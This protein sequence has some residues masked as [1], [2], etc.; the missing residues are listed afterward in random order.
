[1]CSILS[2]ALYKLHIQPVSCCEDPALEV[3]A[4]SPGLESKEF[5]P[6]LCTSELGSTA[7]STENS[8]VCRKLLKMFREFYHFT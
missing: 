8:S 1:M 2:K 3:F 6:G 5:Q 4:V 7:Q